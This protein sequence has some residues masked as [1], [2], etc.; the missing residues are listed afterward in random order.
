MISFTS[1]KPLTNSRGVYT[2]PILN[3]YHFESNS[4]V[5]DTLSEIV[6]RSQYI[7]IKT[8]KD[9]MGIVQAYKEALDKIKENE[10]ITDEQKEILR[11]EVQESIN[12]ILGF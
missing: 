5:S 4:N 7:E 12:I 8:Y 3:F 9:D 10:Y 1:K 11:K 2:V 6:D